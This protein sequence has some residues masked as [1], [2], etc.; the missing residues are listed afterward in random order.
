M[1]AP[2][3]ARVPEEEIVY[4][5]E[6]CGE[7]CSVCLET[8]GPVV[9]PAPPIAGR[10]RR[11][12]RNLPDTDCM[13][14]ECGHHFHVG[15]MKHWLKAIDWGEE[16]AACCPLCRAKVKGS[17]ELMPSMD[18]Q[19][20]E[21]GSDLITELST[22]LWAPSRAEVRRAEVRQAEVRQRRSTVV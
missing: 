18:E 20:G 3:P 10:Q 7:L 5:K 9:K 22:Q 4:E 2:A 8:M 16:D 1:P 12:R 19:N 14:I 21:W 13:K 17:H 15:C 11:R 6:L